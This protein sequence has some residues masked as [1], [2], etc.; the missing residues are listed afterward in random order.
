MRT[1]RTLVAVAAAGFGLGVPAAVALAQ[2]GGFDDVPPDQV[3]AEGIAW[4]VENGIAAG[5][6]TGRFCPSD[7]VS[8]S[9]MATFLH[10][11]SG[12]AEGVDPVVDADRVDG[13]DSTE[14][15][16]NQRFVTQGEQITDQ[17]FAN[18][19]VACPEGTVAIG[20]GY[21]IQDEVNGA[22][23]TGWLAAASRPATDLGGWVVTVVTPDA[24]PRD[25][26]VTVFA[27]CAEV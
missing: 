15:V 20:G 24:A 12:T 7:P 14:L 1:T 26:F 11:L 19:T 21:Q 16:R 6:Q 4:L 9:Q 13:L 5:C 8:R 25:A 17:N 3:H 10:R 23:S 2:V 22:V 18:V 27:S